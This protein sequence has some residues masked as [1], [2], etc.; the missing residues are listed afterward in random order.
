M[1]NSIFEIPI[2]PQ[3]LNIN[4]WRTKTIKSINLEIIRNLVEYS[5]KRFLR[6]KFLL[7][8]F[9]M[10]LFEVGRYYD[11]LCSL[12]GAKELNFQWKTP[13]NVCFFLELLEQGCLTSLGGFEWFFKK[14]CLILSV[15]EK[16]KN[17][18]FEI[19][20][21]PQ[22]LNFNN[23]KATNAKSISLDIIR[24]LIEYSTENVLFKSILTLT[25][26]YC[27]T[28]LLFES[29][30]V[31]PPS[32]VHSFI[33]LFVCLFIYLF[34]LIFFWFCLMLLVPEKLKNSIF[35]ITIIPQTLNIIN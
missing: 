35:E 18:I 27:F 12:Q 16:F 7:S 15:L 19:P 4:N 11:L 23:L 8:P 6:G 1:K 30:S 32:R 28:I 13:K 26:Y 22:I 5:L 29:R 33:Y 24:K 14:F 21:I 10:L 31:D 2:I 17:S 3:I 34:I 9:E 20:I 25:L